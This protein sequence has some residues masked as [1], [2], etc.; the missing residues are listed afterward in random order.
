VHPWSGNG[1]AS[2]FCALVLGVL[3]K[4]SGVR[5]IHAL[6]TPEYISAWQPEPLRVRLRRNI[7][8]S[9][10]MESIVSMNWSVPFA[11]RDNVGERWLRRFI[12]AVELRWS[13]YSRWSV[14][15][16][17]ATRLHAMSDRELK[18]IGL[19]RS[20][21]DRAVTIVP[22]GIVEVGGHHEP[23]PTKWRGVTRTDR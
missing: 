5:V 22:V 12:A 14:E 9:E 8:T 13:A 2:W 3:G 19:V 15:Q 16:H 20:E 18:D 7:A 11:A 1:S 4:T 6:T 10:L 17:A 23:Q 21:I